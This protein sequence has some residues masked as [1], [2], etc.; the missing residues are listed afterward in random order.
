[1]P[2]KFVISKSAS[3]KYSFAL[4][5]ENGETILA[6]QMY[7]RASSAREGIDAV[8]SSALRDEMFERLTSVRGEPYFTLKSSNGQVIGTSEM[9]ATTRSRDSGIESVRRNAPSASLEDD[10][11]TRP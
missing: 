7:T 5:A 1:M 6:S 4:K 9:Y 11:A 8:R 10:G 3:G 2:G